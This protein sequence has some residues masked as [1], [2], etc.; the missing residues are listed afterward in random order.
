LGERLL[1]K[2][3]HKL[4]RCILYCLKVSFFFPITSCNPT[5][6]AP[7]LEP[8]SFVI[9]NA[10]EE[11]SEDPLL[12]IADYLPQDW[13]NLFNDPQLD[14]FIQKALERNPTIHLAH[15]NILLAA[16]NADYVRSTLYPTLLGTGDVARE[17]LSQTGLAFPNSTG[18]AAP[19]TGG[20][21]PP[22]PPGGTLGLPVYF[23]QWET[24]LNFSYNFDVWDKNRNMVRAALGEMYSNVADE[25]YT[26]L[27][28]GIA[29]AKVYFELQIDYK[30]QEIANAM[31]E[32][33]TKYF[34]FVRQ[35]QVGSL[36]NALTLHSAE[37][38]TT[39][40]KQNL[41]Q[42]Q[43]DIA[44]KEYQLKTYLADN[45]LEDIFNTRV[46]EQPLP[47]IPIPQ[48]I[49]LR[50][51]AHRPDIISQL[52]L[53]YSAGRQI[54]VAKAGFYPDFNL[55]AIFGFQSLELNQLFKRKS[56]YYDIDPAFALPIFEGGRLEANLSGSEVN[57]DR[58][59]FQYNNLVLNAAKEVLDGIA[60]LRNSEQQMIEYKKQTQ[61]QSENL[62]LTNLRVHNNLNSGIDYLVSEYTLLIAQ[63]QEL[64]LIGKTIDAILLLIKALGGG[65]EACYEEGL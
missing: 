36:E 6:R 22:F 55:N 42:I 48:N 54:E 14:I 35:R 60:V 13:W 10:L 38:N 62:K 20:V 28:L 5:N 21:T 44:V 25:A 4:L 7:T 16:D 17:K 3:R 18:S 64:V 34:E 49:P 26:R 40:S 58:A 1:L 56:I 9:E 59:I 63:D 23:T 19:S 31:I 15:A 65:Y 47:R 45:F 41:L 33:R 46:V 43:G 37:F 50:L 32:N 30:R 39:G 27:Q 57:Y 12:D 8:P 29:V 53:I 51:I 61:Y 2:L 24:Q 52:W 11:A